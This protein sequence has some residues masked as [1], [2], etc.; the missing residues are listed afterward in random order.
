MIDL[1][2]P[3]SNNCKILCLRHTYKLWWVWNFA[4]R[5]ESWKL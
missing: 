2:L 3:T 5:A 4:W 1:P